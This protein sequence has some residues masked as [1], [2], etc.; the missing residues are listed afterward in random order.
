MP[1]F[2]VPIRDTWATALFDFGLS[3]AQLFAREWP[4]GL[5]RELVY[6]RSPVNSRGLTAPARLVW[7]VSGAAPGAQAIRAV[8]HLTEVVVDDHK[9]LFH[10]FKRLGVYDAE[11]VRARAHRKTGQV[12][13]LR[14]SNTE[15]LPRPVGLDTYRRL[16]TGN[17]KSKSVVLQSVHPIH[18]HVFVSLYRLATATDA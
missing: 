11:Q 16:A 8:S 10:R 4:L 2:F 7:Y 15:L 1:N 14:F 3:Q 6:Y 13:A 17:A 9:R 12:M 18:E 5:R